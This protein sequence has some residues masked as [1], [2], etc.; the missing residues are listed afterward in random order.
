MNDALTREVQRQHKV[1][2]ILHKKQATT[3]K[4]VERYSQKIQESLRRHEA[5]KRTYEMQQN[6]LNLAN[7]GI[8][9][10]K[11][12]LNNVRGATTA[13][14]A[15]EKK[16]PI[17]PSV[18]KNYTNVTN[19]LNKNKED[20]QKTEKA[21]MEL[22]VKQKQELKNAQKSA[23]KEPQSRAQ[24]VEM[25]VVPRPQ[26]NEKTMKEPQ[27]RAQEVE[28]KVVPKPQLNKQT[29]NAVRNAMQRQLKNRAQNGNSATV[30]NVGKRTIMSK[31]AMNNADTTRIVE[32]IY[33][34]L[35]LE[36][37]Q[38]EVRQKVVDFIKNQHGKYGGV[39]SRKDAVP[40]KNDIAKDL[41]PYMNVTAARKVTNQIY[42]EVD[43]ELN[44]EKFPGNTPQSRQ[45]SQAETTADSDTESV[46]E[47]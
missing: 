14:S 44:N 39:V 28:M 9:E 24:E 11:R 43:K 21:R 27:S 18:T 35:M 20:Y 45:V 19:Q 41:R 6:Q 8:A 34:Q 4:N 40:F 13:I 38:A 36:S 16:K 26:L 30:L 42:N 2:E 5:L 22:E 10:S 46:A 33:R 3:A 15:P 7:K 29:L 23:K 31:Q 1:G 25:K 37:T 17:P 47:S 32:E 12:K